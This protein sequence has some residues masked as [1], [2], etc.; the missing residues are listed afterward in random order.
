MTQEELEDKFTDNLMFAG[1]EAKDIASAQNRIGRLFNP[2][3]NIRECV[4]ALA[5]IG[6]KP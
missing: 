2:K 4:K 5:T 3:S 1:F 6:E